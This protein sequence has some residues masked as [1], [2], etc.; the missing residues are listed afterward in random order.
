MKMNLRKNS[1]E[2]LNYESIFSGQGQLVA[3]QKNGC[4]TRH[5]LGLATF[6]IEDAVLEEALSRGVTVLQ[7]RGDLIETI[8]A[9]A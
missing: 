5:N 7:R 4:A 1:A 8:P 9:A 2:P 3:S 6:S